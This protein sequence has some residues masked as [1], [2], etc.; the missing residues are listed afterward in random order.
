M[1]DERRVA[2]SS[3]Y[4]ETAPD[5]E[6]QVASSSAYIETAPDDELQVASSSAYIETAPDDELQVASVSAYIE[7]YVPEVPEVPV[8][9]ENT[10]KSSI[11]PT[12]E[13]WLTDAFGNPVAIF[14]EFRSIDLARKIN[15]VGVLELVI[16]AKYPRYIFGIDRRI[17]V[18][19]RAFR[20]PPALEG[21]T[22]WF[23]RSIEEFLDDDGVEFLKIK[24]FDAN[25]ILKR[26]IVPYNKGNSNLNAD[27]VQ[28][29]DDMM[30]AIMRE[31]YGALALDTDRNISSHLAVQ[32]DATLAPQVFKSFSRKVVYNVLKEIGE[33]SYEYG[34]YLAFDIVYNPSAKTFEFRTYIGQRGTDR[35][36]T[37][38]KNILIVGAEY[39]SLSNVTLEDDQS[40]TYNYVYAGGQSIGDIRA[41]FEVSDPDSISISPFNRIEYFENASSTDDLDELETAANAALEDGRARVRFEGELQLGS[42]ITYGVDIKF[43]D[44]VT[45][46]FKGQRFD[47]WVDAYSLRIEGSSDQIDIVLRSE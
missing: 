31:N 23:I 6:L 1:A 46:E 12:Y 32:G 29:A 47:V 34:T 39:G 2:S 16:P 7:W 21:E 25:H 3:A 30:K 43:G 33:T 13:V 5:D 37:S 4:V 24:A 8:V 26:R 27:K 18:W 9:V 20:Q 17:E 42:N 40:D 28:E 41:V 22:P 44:K 35:T 38:G 15:D 14:D 45:A 19:R 11:P 10:V 36:V